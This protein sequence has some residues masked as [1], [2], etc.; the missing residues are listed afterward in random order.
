MNSL[1][2]DL[3]RVAAELREAHD[4]QA[5]LTAH[6]A[7]LLAK[8]ESLQRAA[9]TATA[10]ADATDLGPMTKAQAIVAILKGAPSSMTLQDIA[11]AL[12]DA[13]KYAKASGVSVYMDGLLKD[14]LAI[15][16]A[17]GHYVAAR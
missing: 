6:I 17:R 4:E 9:F 1:S 8:Q 16:V 14:G 7:G 11:T 3:K 13:G 12:T 15:R 5:R 2:E 10:P